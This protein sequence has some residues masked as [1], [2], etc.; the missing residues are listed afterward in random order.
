[1]RLGHGLVEPIALCAQVHDALKRNH[2]LEIPDKLERT[3]RCVC[4]FV[5][6]FYLLN[7]AKVTDH[8]LGRREALAELL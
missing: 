3:G 4:L 1:M 6:N 8:S 7:A 2:H 5:E